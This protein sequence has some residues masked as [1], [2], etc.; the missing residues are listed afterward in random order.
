MPGRSRKHPPDKSEFIAPT[1]AYPS[2]KAYQF[3]KSLKNYLKE[4]YS[5]VK[6]L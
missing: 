1:D 4:L 2:E 3:F 6:A 5:N